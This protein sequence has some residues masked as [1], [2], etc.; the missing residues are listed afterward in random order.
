MHVIKQ[1]NIRQ[2]RVCSDFLSEHILCRGGDKVV[3][4][5]SPPLQKMDFEESK[6]AR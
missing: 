5:L 2:Q 1:E 4:T 6:S 3:M